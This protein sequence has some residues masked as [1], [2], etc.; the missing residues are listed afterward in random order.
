LLL[1]QGQFERTPHQLGQVRV[2]V[3]GAS[4]SSIAYVSSSHRDWD[5]NRYESRQQYRDAWT[6]TEAVLKIQSRKTLT[7]LVDGTAGHIGPEEARNWLPRR[8]GR[9]NR[10]GLSRPAC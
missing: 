3:N 1:V 8:I 10:P 7:S 2:S 5:G 9:Q 6:K 4:A